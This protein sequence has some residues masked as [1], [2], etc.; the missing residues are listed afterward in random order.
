MIILNG[1]GLL[2]F[3]FKIRVDFWEIGRVLL[4][5]KVYREF[6]VGQVCPQTCVVFIEIRIGG[7]VR[8]DRSNRASNLDPKKTRTARFDKNEARKNGPDVGPVRKIQP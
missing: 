7:P 8:F 6:L 1:I 4:G 5:E 2:R 3:L